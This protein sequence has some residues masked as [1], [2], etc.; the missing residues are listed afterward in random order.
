MNINQS[1]S[2]FSQEDINSMITIPEFS[3]FWSFFENLLHLSKILLE[4]SKQRMLRPG[5]EHG[6]VTLGGQ[7]N[8]HSHDIDEKQIDSQI[9]A[10]FEICWTEPNNYEN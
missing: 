10:I 8:D 1:N 9:H 5:F 7:I 2:G 3:L 4:E 6:I